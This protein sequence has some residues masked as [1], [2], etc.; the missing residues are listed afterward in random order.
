[1]FLGRA[2]RSRERFTEDFLRA[3]GVIPVVNLQQVSNIDATA[4]YWSPIVETN[5][6]V[7]T[8]HFYLDDAIVPSHIDHRFYGLPLRCLLLG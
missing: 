7:Y 8:L 4:N 6:H 5:I 3:G 1:M 2:K